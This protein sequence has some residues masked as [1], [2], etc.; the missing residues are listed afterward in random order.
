[1]LRTAKDEV[2]WG[3]GVWA[4]RHKYLAFANG[5]DMVDMDCRRNSIS[6][7]NYGTLRLQTHCAAATPFGLPKQCLG[8]LSIRIMFS[9]IPPVLVVFGCLS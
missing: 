7:W 4:P 8:D 6:C 2:A 1:M 9:T 3:C 5:R